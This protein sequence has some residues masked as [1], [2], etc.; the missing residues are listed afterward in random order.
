M[1][2]MPA[3]L[4]A[5]EMRE[6]HVLNHHRFNDGPGDITSTAGRETGTPA[7]SYWIRYGSIVKIHSHANVFRRGRVEWPPPAAQPVHP[8]SVLVIALVAAAGRFA[9]NTRFLLFYAIPCS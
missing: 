4:T 1:C 8:D 6:V 9:D 3:L 7:V 5:A 2:C